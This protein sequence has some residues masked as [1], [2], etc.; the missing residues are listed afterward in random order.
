MKNLSD[1]ADHFAIWRQH[2]NGND[3]TYGE[4]SQVTGVPLPKVKRLCIANGWRFAD[5]DP[6][7]E[8]D[9]SRFSR[10]GIDVLENHV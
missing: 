6:I 1:Q 4:V 5:D 10:N 3:C 9:F 8:V 7:E 2:K